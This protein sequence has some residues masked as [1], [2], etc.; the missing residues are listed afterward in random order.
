MYACLEH[1]L[2]LVTLLRALPLTLHVCLDQF[3][4]SSTLCCLSLLQAV[5]VI[6]KMFLD[7]ER[8]RDS[9][10]KTL[11]AGTAASL[12]LAPELKLRSNYAT[13]MQPGRGCLA[14]AQTLQYAAVVGTGMMGTV[15]VCTTRPRGND[16]VETHHLHIVDVTQV[17]EQKSFVKLRHD[18]S[19]V[20]KCIC[21]QA[22][23]TSTSS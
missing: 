1:G 4:Y 17:S 22:L 13:I 5:S 11:S 18:D 8:D 16:D 12:Q 15:K 7:R 20:T 23:L 9:T 14:V 6:S 3:H 19:S 2:R 10:F 21:A